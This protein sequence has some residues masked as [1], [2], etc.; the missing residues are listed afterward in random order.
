AAE[1]ALL[2]RVAAGA[3]LGLL[4]AR[5]A[6]LPPPNSGADLAAAGRTARP[7]DL[8]PLRRRDVGRGRPDV[9]PG[10]GETGRLTLPSSP[11]C[12]SGA[13]S[14]LLKNSLDRADNC[15]YN[16]RGG[17]GVARSWR[18]RNPATST[19]SPGRA[20]RCACAC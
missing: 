10:S 2:R 14:D 5:A 6:H 7:G 12:P 9:L 16:Y 20:S 3:D 8:R 17:D 18:S 1:P 4:A 13:M 11:P 15:T 19:P